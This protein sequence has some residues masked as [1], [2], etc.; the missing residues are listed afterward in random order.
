MKTIQT[1]RGRI[2]ALAGGLTLLAGGFAVPATAQSLNSTTGGNATTGATVGSNATAPI[3]ECAWALNDYNHNW[4]APTTPPTVPAPVL[5]QYGNDDSPNVSAGSPCVDDGF[6]QAKMTSNP[7]TTKVIDV[8]PNA[9]DEPSEQFVELWG[10]ITS[11]NANPS[12]YFDVYH[13]D[14]SLKKQ[15]DAAKYADSSTPERCEGPV[16]MFNAAQSL[17]GQMT[18]PAQTNMIGECKFQ[19]KSFWYAAFGISKHQPNGLYKVVLTAA[20]AGGLKSTQTIYINVQG[21]MNLEKDFTNVSFGAVG[22]NSHYTQNGTGNFNFE[23]AD[24]SGNQMTSVRNTGN[25]GVALGVRFASMCLTTAASCSDAKRIDHF[26][27]KFGVGILANL[28]S[29][30]NTSLASALLSYNDPATPGG[31]NFLTDTLP[32]ALG[33]Q[34]N[35]DL[36]IKRTLCPNDVGKL[37]FSIWT[38]N[39][40]GGTYDSGNATGIQLV[41]RPNPICITDP[42]GGQHVY[43]ANLGTPQ[44]GNPPTP[45]SSTHWA[46]A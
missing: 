11:N 24:L 30:G 32:A 9:H 44:F 10:A 13:P 2:V 7:Y 40:E 17:T 28:Q 34:H 8:K 19:Q 23:G 3:I 42:S 25:T 31:P 36:D 5:M 4:P 12:V 21:F 14:G 15:I 35:F 27:A 46:A 22:I 39:I 16:G 45:F 43:P 37:E 1:R 18:Y 20:A 26:D 38:E 41:A 29:L 33:P 6:G